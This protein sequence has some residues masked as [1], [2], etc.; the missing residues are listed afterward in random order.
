MSYTAGLL[1]P[2]EDRTMFNRENAFGLIFLGLCAVV[3]GV[4]LYAIVT[5]NQLRLDVPPAVGWGLTI[6]VI[7]LIVFGM[8]RNVR[9][10]R[11]R[12]GGRSWPDPQTGGRTLW[13]RIRGRK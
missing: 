8:T 7:G 5:G 11:Q 4:L 13:D 6:L 12:G 9:G 10:R 2:H 3:A 1:S